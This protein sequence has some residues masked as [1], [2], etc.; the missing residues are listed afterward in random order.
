MKT[1]HRRRFAEPSIEEI[2][3]GA[4]RWAFSGGLAQA[5]GE[6]LMVVVTRAMAALVIWG[7]VLG[8]SRVVWCLGW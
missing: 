6:T 4:L 3:R 8:L 5:G 1:L 7:T 2:G